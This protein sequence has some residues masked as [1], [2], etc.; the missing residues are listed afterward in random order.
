MGVVN[1][2]LFQPQGS[3]VPLSTR[4]IYRW[5]YTR[6]KYVHGSGGALTTDGNC[7]TEIFQIFSSFSL[8]Y[9]A[10]SGLRN[11]LRFSEESYNPVDMDESSK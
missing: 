1:F 7:I 9:V 11:R 4:G 6:V 2:E 10:L 3:V 5:E 8:S